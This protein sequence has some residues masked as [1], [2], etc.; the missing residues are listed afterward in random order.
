[1]HRALCAPSVWKNSLPNT[2]TGTT[3]EIEAIF[4]TLACKTVSRQLSK[5][6]SNCDRGGPLRFRPNHDFEN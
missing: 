3:N 5:R 2:G 6:R 1:M 4:A